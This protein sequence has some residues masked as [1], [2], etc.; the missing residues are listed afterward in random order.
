MSYPTHVMFATMPP[1]PVLQTHGRLEPGK[2]LRM[3]GTVSMNDRHI[4][5]SGGRD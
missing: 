5:K 3:F 2:W 4:Q 1:F